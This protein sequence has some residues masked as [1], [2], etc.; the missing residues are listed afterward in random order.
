MR[1][2]VSLAGIGA[3]VHMISDARDTIESLLR[4]VVEDILLRIT[5]VPEVPI[6]LPRLN[7][8]LNHFDVGSSILKKRCMLNE[9]HT[10]LL[11]KIEV[12]WLNHFQDGRL[13]RC[14]SI[15]HTNILHV[16]GRVSKT[17]WRVSQMLW[18]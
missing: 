18:S 17:S 13:L 9:R 11:M 10:V 8:F 15:H 7:I 4:H 6:R 3:I 5:C 12:E 14:R 16:S 1:E 2:L